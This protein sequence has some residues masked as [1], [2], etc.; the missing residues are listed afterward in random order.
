MKEISSRSNIY[1]KQLSLLNSKKYIIEHGM[2]LVEGRNLV[3]EAI[4]AGVVM[5]LLITDEKMYSIYDIPKTLVTEEIINKLS[6]NRSNRGA[7][8][9]CCYEPMA[10]NL[11]LVKRIVVLENI[12]NPGNLGTIIRTALAFGFDAV[13]TLGE[14][15]FVYN[16][17]VIRAAQGSLFKMPIMQIKQMHGLESFR[18][19]R[20]VLSDASTNIEDVAITDDK[21][22][23]VFGNEANGLTD[24][25]LKEWPGHNVKIDTKSVESLNLSIAAS[26]A[27]YKFKK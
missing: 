8:A 11:N 15:T 4:Q 20:F 27:M 12:N 19:Y 22:A 17:K 5:D 26:I 2:Y 24:E 9:V 16:E 13:I 25:L 18:P 1:I 10:V 23:L 3:I 7:I 6:T 14:S 21:Y